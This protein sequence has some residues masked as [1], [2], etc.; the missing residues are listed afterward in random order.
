[1]D[2]YL[3]RVSNNFIVMFSFTYYLVTLFF[4]GKSQYDKIPC[5][6][7]NTYYQDLYFTEIFLENIS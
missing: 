5:E 7:H 4:V 1:M 6:F 2:V 3:R